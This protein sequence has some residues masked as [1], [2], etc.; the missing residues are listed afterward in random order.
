MATAKTYIVEPANGNEKAYTVSAERYVFDNQSGR[1][2]FYN[3]TGDDAETV[4][5]LIN[6]SVRQQSDTVDE[7]DEG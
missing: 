2:M 4:A 6:V 5:N 3:G 1:H 7:A